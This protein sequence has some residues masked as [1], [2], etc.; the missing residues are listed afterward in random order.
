MQYEY[1]VPSHC[2]EGGTELLL[3]DGAL[4][5]LGTC[6]GRAGDGVRNPAQHRPPLDSLSAPLLLGRTPSLTLGAHRRSGDPGL[7]R[8]RRRCARGAGDRTSV[9]VPH[10]L[11]ASEERSCATTAGVG[12]PKAYHPSPGHADS[13]PQTG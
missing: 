7:G 12:P 1:A 4:E 11:D 2:V 5:V 9:A 10:R 6:G 3:A 13:L 8:R